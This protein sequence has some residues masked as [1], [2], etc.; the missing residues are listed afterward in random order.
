[1]GR[2]QG[3]GVQVPAR[4]MKSPTN[5]TVSELDHAPRMPNALGAMRPV[6]F[7]PSGL[8][9]D[10]PARVSLPLPEGVAHAK[11]R[12]NAYVYNEKGRWE[13]AR[14]VSVDLDNGFMTAEAHHFS[15]YAAAQSQLDLELSLS[16]AAAS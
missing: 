15:V 11:A 4:A 6:R 9:F 8:V 5:L 12:L 13:R 3:A 10:A 1:A 14:I 2:M 16:E 7:G